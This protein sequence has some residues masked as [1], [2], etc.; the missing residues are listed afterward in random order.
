MKKTYLLLTL[1]FAVAIVF[2]QASMDEPYRPVYH[3][4]PKAH[5]MNDPNGMVYYNGTYHLFSS[6][7]P[8][9]LPGDRCIGAM[10]PVRT[11]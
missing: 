8:G 4:T 2:G 9:G 3:F 7:I 6:I 5:W 10:Q 11:L 1:F